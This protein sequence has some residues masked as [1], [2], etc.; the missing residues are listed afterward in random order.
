MYLPIH[1]TYIILFVLFLNHK[2]ILIKHVGISH[3]LHLILN[4]RPVNNF[5]DK[6]F[7]YY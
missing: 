3:I 6:T 7:F 4:N 1:I 2:Y 5:V